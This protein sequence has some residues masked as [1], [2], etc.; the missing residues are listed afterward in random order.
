MLNPKMD[1]NNRRP[2][3][4]A[5]LQAVVLSLIFTSSQ[6]YGQAGLIINE[7]SNGVTGTEEYFEMLLVGTA[8]DCN[9]DLR[10]WIFDDNNGDFS[11]GPA[12]SCGIAPGHARLSAT[13]PTWS[14]MPLGAIIVVY[15]NSDVGAN[16][17]ADDPTDANGDLV[18][19][20]PISHPS[21]EVASGVGSCTG[22]LTPVGCNACPGNGN[23]G[24][25]GNS[26]GA[27]GTWNCLGLRNGSGDAAQTRTPTGAY[28]HGISYGTSSITGGPQ[29]T[30]VLTGSGSGQTFIFSTGDP[31]DVT[32]FSNVPASTSETPGAPNN[33]LNQTFIT[34]LQG[35]CPLPVEFEKPLTA[36]A[37]E[38]GVLLEWSTSQELNFDHFVVE[39][40]DE[41]NRNF[42]PIGTVAGNGAAY[43]YLDDAPQNLTVWYRLRMVDL[44][45]GSEN[46][47]VAAVYHIR[48]E[49]DLEVNAF[50][51]PA[52]SQV[53]FLMTGAEASTLQIF[54]LQ[55][56]LTHQQELGAEASV[57]L[58]QWAR[59][60]YLWQVNAAGKV[61]RGKLQVQ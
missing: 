28:F 58:S 1:K 54:D 36:R 42:S 41:R 40:A 59:G 4:F 53:S 31:T 43:D 44:D 34:T 39:R 57:D 2:L 60:L 6:A 16:M 45:G 25:S 14:A 37:T 3:T 47:R 20:L 52:S 22:T 10:G 51:N 24:Y 55:G 56:R 19:V 30:K 46:S 26:Y 48:P 5:F 9:V 18:Y 7:V 11:C 23:S 15:N 33:A 17:P 61:V 12:S 32:N 13:D 38:E 29:N 49:G 8:S 50:P 35:L 21:L 27:G